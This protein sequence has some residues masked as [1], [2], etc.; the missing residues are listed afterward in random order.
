MPIVN[1]DRPVYGSATL[2]SG[3]VVPACL[4]REGGHV[5]YFDNEEKRIPLVKYFEPDPP[6]EYLHED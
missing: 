6:Q 2:P 5:Q 3:A 1:L 4:K